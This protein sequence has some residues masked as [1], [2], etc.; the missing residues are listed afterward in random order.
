METLNSKD[1]LPILIEFFRQ[2]PHFGYQ[3]PV[4]FRVGDTDLL[5]SHGPDGALVPNLPL[6]LPKFAGLGSA[7]LRLAKQH[8]RA[9]LELDDYANE[10]LFYVTA[11]GVSVSNKRYETTVTTSYDDLFKKWLAFAED[12]WQVV[13]QRNPEEASSSWWRLVHEEPGPQIS[14]ILT[15]PSLFEEEE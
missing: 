7:C 10:L 11:E 9:G 15:S 12:L 2:A 14:Q 5:M 4:R 1:K 8:G 13:S 6:F 3:V